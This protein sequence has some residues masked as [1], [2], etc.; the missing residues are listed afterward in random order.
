MEQKYYVIKYRNPNYDIMYCINGTK[1]KESLVTYWKQ[2]ESPIKYELLELVEVEE[3]KK[4]IVAD[5]LANR[6]I[7]NVRKTE[8]NIKFLNEITNGRFNKIYNK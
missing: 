2:N 7:L 1:D 8:K 3:N 6:K 4:D 5:W